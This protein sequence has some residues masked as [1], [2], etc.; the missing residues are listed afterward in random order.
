MV[1]NRHRGIFVNGVVLYTCSCMH[2]AELL[3]SR[4]SVLFAMYGRCEPALVGID[5]ACF[6]LG[7]MAEWLLEWSFYLLGG[8]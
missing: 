1:S 8:T 4:V 7:K 5:P 2:V 3:V 6:W